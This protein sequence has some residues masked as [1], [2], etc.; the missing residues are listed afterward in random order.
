MIPFC[1]FCESL[2]AEMHSCNAEARAIQQ[3]LQARIVPGKESM[4][5]PGNGTA[6]P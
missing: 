6:L 4:R 3:D 2:F 1:K 5:T